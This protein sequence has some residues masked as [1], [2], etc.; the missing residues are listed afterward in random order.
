M[1]APTTDRAGGVLLGQAC[2]DALGVPYELA[3]PPEGDAKMLGG[4][5]GPYEPGEWSDDTQMALCVAQVAA[6]GADLRSE[7]ALDEIAARFEAWRTGGAS[8]IGI[9]TRAVLADAATR[10]GRPAERL[11][12]AARDYHARTGRSASNGALMRTSVVGLHALGDPVVTAEAAR[13]VAA[14]THADPLAG[15]ACVLWCEAIRL[16]VTEERLD[17]GA[18][19]DLLPP[20]H[21]DQWAAWI[22]AAER[23]DAGPRFRDNGY[24]VTAL[25]AAWHAI[26]TTDG[27]GPAHLERA[28]QA[29]VRIGGD[30]DTVAAIAGGLLGARWGASAV[31][32]R[33]RRMLHGWPGLDAE[34]LVRLAVRTARGGEFSQVE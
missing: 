12:A 5:L 2:G 13:A 22:R 9:L 26:V 24:T 1:D 23:P 8:D 17:V 4:G 31:P 3:A 32:Q 10:S 29:A 6:T 11:R 30:T 19:L 15:D 20:K 28:L 16:A 7:E 27:D 21:Q 34:D 33:W 18:G 14:L 25:Q